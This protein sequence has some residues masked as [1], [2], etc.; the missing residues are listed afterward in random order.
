M[1]K[2]SPEKKMQPMRRPDGGK[3]R[4]IVEP[5]EDRGLRLA[6][7]AAGGYAE[8][9]N[10]LGIRSQSVFQWQRVPLH[11]VVEVEKATGVPR[12]KL[13]PELFS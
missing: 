12:E 6:L 8:L 13:R 1:R 11:R 9:A 2:A 3:G 10:A 7:Q 5:V 4:Q